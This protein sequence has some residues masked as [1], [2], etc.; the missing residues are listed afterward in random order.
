MFFIRLRSDRDVFS[1]S[2]GSALVAVPR[3]LCL[4][5]SFQGSEEDVNLAVPYMSDVTPLSV[6]PG[7]VSLFRVELKQCGRMVLRCNSS[8]VGGVI[9]VA[10]ILRLGGKEVRPEALSVKTVLSRCLGP[11]TD[12]TSVLSFPG[13]TAIHFTPI[14]QISGSAYCIRDHLRVGD[15]LSADWVAVGKVLRMVRERHI[16]FCDVVWNHMSVDAPFLVKHPNAGFSVSLDSKAIGLCNSPHL[17]PALALDL[18]LRN[19]S[20]FQLTSES[21]V[22]ALLEHVSKSV[23]QEVRLWEYF[24]LD[25]E[26]SV[27]S[28]VPA[29]ERALVRPCVFLFALFVGSIFSKGLF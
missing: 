22:I 14:Q 5:A 3:G 4:H 16:L 8:V 11:L 13:Y 25:V 20:G 24:V 26:E 15:S 18:A 9:L 29:K 2:T 19:V 17:A 6:F 21:D 23:W 12:W 7:E 27:K 1:C 10:P 28:F